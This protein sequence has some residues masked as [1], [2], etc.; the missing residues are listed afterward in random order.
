MPT[1]AI[2]GMV[3]AGRGSA[4]QPMSERL[5]RIVVEAPG[6]AWFFAYGSL[7]WAPGFAAAEIRP[8]LLYGYHRR[9]CVRSVLYRGTPDDPGLSLGLDRGGSCR[10]RALRIAEADRPAVFDY[11]ARREM[12]EEIYRC[13][14]V[15]LRTPAG[16][17]A[18]HTLVVNRANALYDGA[19]SEAAAAAR[20]ARCR[21]ESGPNI[22][23]LAA[24]VEHLDALGIGEGAMHRLLDK[25]RRLAA[26]DTK[27]RGARHDGRQ[28]RET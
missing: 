4:G 1:V 28:R 7:M 24:T 13:T 26:P 25:A 10:G 27:E 21:G 22:D 5:R 6:D 18:G 11:L 2:A 14:P 12:P 15:R 16:I 3:V 19:V 8:A 23:Y 9:F 20:I 17:V